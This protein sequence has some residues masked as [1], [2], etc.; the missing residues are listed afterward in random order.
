VTPTARPFAALV[1]TSLALGAL[2]GCGESSSSEETA[3]AGGTEAPST[4]QESSSP[5][6]NESSAYPGEE[7]E[8][9][10]SSHAS[11][12][13]FCNEHTCIGNFTTQ[14]GMIV[15]CYDGSYSHDGGHGLACKHHGGANKE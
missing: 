14:H 3:N 5:S 12:R 15:E 4:T 11:D 6:G 1:L 7:D 8:I 13:R 2:V 9:G 10:S